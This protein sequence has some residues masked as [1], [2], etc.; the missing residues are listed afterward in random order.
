MEEL[1]VAILGDGLQVMPGSHVSFKV[2][3][4]NLGTVVDR[5][6]CDVLGLDPAWSTVTPA[7]LELLPDT[8]R[9]AGPSGQGGRPTVGTFTVTIQP[10]RHPSALAREWPIA[11][12]VRSENDA[13]IHR[14]EETSVVILPFGLI[15]AQLTPTASRSR[16]STTPSLRLANG[17][18]QTEHVTYEGTDSAGHL[19]FGFSPP[20]LELK[21]GQAAVVK[22]RLSPSGANVLGQA[23]TSSY[24]IQVRGSGFG[25]APVGLTGS[26][27][28]LSLIP[29]QAPWFAA[30]LVALGMTGLVVRSI[31]APDMGHVVTSPAPSQ[32]ASSFV[33]SIQPP[34]DAPSPSGQPS[35]APPSV[36]APPS[37][38][39]S[40]SA[41]TPTP[42]PTTSPTPALSPTP[43]VA[44][45]A[46][47]KANELSAAGIDL[48][49]PAGVTQATTD[50]AGLIQRFEKG[51]VYRSPTGVVAAIRGGLQAT[52]LALG[53][54]PGPVS[55]LGYPKV[56]EE[57][58]GANH[59]FQRFDKGVLQCS[60]GHCAYIVPNK[61]FRLWRD[62]GSTIGYP[63]KH[64]GPVS[65][66]A[67]G[68]EFASGIIYVNPQTD[69]HAVCTLTG[70]VI[71]ATTPMTNCSSY[72]A[73]VKG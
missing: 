4:R 26:H 68:T 49:P 65:G 10:P 23:L 69:F 33:A 56:E 59:P 58:D 72:V 35:S 19:D 54:N 53:G 61:V 52:W 32:A 37:Q 73:I 51:R 28:Q 70:Q 36:S 11:V 18:N 30:V 47:A 64:G 9:I 71:H 24:S 31:V 42:T 12:N 34:T 14:I 60:P 66:G 16:L 20:R 55:A 1:A 21:P 39:P 45:W 29:S 6:F 3:V 50:G 41:V 57:L 13:R 67:L 15:E 5:Y 17:G 40:P 44:D 62:Y 25:T 48:G 8:G 22:L 2:E 27:A 43:G 46:L 63:V 38:A 7:A